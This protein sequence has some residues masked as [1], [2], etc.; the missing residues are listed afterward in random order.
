VALFI[1]GGLCQSIHLGPENQEVGDLSAPHASNRSVAIDDIHFFSNK[2]ST[3]EEFLHTFNTINLAG[4]Q[5]VLVSDAAPK[6]IGQLSE[7]LVNR[8][9]SGMVVKIDAPD[10]ETRYRICKQRS[11]SMLKTA[12]SGKRSAAGKRTRIPDSVLRYVAEHVHTNARELEGALLK[13]IAYAA[14]QNETI[15]LSMTKD[16]LADHVE[17][18]DPIVHLSDIESTVAA[19][20][21][22]TPAH[23]HST[24]KDKTVSLARHYSMYLA[25]KHTNMSSSEVGRL[26]GNKN[27]AT[28]LV[29]CK[30]IEDLVERNAE[31]HWRGPAGNKIARAK[32]TLA[33]LEGSISK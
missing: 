18:C 7:K 6:Q 10:F 15:S 33:K 30:R 9:V 3:Q 29:A 1:S 28:V 17:R 21:G 24:K 32:A 19:Y 25:R 16:V 11:A 12:F 27:H 20:F 22:V 8:F 5:V 14:L 31:L 13:V 23:L 26:M 4:K 2:P